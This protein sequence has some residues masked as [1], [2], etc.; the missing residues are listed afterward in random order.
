[1]QSH[2]RKGTG[3]SAGL[4]YHWL[5]LA[6]ALSLFALNG[7]WDFPL[8]VWLYPL[9]LLRFTRTHRPFNG[10]LTASL[11]N[12]AAACVMA[13]QIGLGLQIPILAAVVAVAIFMS[14]PYLVDRLVRPSLNG[15][16]G[17]LIFPLGFVAADYLKTLLSPFGS[18]GSLAYTQYGNLPLLQL[19]AITGISGIV[20]LITWFASVVNWAWEQHFAWPR[21]R[22]GVLL[23]AGLLGL[24]LAG[25]GLRLALFAPQGQTVLVAGISVSQA[26]ETSAMKQGATAFPAFLAGR[27]TQAD[28]EAI[29]LAAD[30]LNSD[31]LT[32]SQRE[33]SA[34]VR[35]VVWPECGA[36]VLQA[37]ERAFLAQ[38]AAVARQAHIYLDMGLCVLTDQ[39]PHEQ[40]QA[41]L[42]DQRGQ[43]V[44]SYDKARPVPGLDVSTP[45][46][47]KVPTV[48]TPYGRISNVICFDGDFPSLSRQAGRAQASLMLVPSNDWRQIDPWHTQD[49]TFR[50]IENGF[51]L[52]RQTSNGLAIAVDYEGRVL[53]SSDYFA[54]G[55]Q[56]LIAS[57]PTQGKQT[58][59]ALVGDLF[60]Q[61]CMA[62]L[63]TLMGIAL[64]LSRRRG[65]LPREPEVLPGDRERHPLYV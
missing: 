26:V 38:A 1:M 56:V 57:V 29:R 12:A 16:A 62:G 18:V 3:N 28:R 24:V 7:T 61:L 40:D 44:W 11:V 33:A 55:D 9:F 2:V 31:L 64:V 54:T 5:V 43:V 27:A 25:G 22:A 14:L 46:N 13:F 59:Y 51:S 39:A 45:G 20:F 49:I 10:F 41:V 60:A 23:Y 37:D 42:I 4:A 53:A 34:G 6:F 32:Q 36:A 19:V 35:V 30:R 58:I 8:A 50:A 21:I 15:I 47:G 65:I 17:T 63:L 52:V 48:N